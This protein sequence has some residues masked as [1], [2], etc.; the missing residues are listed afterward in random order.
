MIRK[1]KLRHEIMRGLIELAEL[2]DRSVQEE[3]QD[4]ADS[5]KQVMD[6]TPVEE[7][8]STVRWT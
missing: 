6:E 1:D 3:I 5:F 7:R 4:L 2:E 8:V